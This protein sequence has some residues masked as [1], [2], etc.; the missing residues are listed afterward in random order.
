MITTAVTSK[1]L[2]TPDMS[3]AKRYYGLS[4]VYF[5][6]ERTLAEDTSDYLYLTVFARGLQ[7]RAAASYTGPQIHVR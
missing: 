3:T 2:K 5:G 1:S 7:S 6:D 4:S